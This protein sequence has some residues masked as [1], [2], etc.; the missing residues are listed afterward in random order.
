MVTVPGSNIVPSGLQSLQIVMELRG[1]VWLLLPPQVLLALLQ[2]CFHLRTVCF[3]LVVDFL[4]G[5]IREFIMGL[6]C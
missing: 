5:G 2:H 4:L 6:N 1:W 3:N